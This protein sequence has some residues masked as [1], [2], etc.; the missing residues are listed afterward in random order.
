MSRFSKSSIWFVHLSPLIWFFRLHGYH[1]R[2]RFW[3]PVIRIE[4]SCPSAFDSE[5]RSCAA[6]WKRGA[7]TQTPDIIKIDFILDLEIWVILQQ[8]DQEAAD[9]NHVSEREREYNVGEGKDNTT[10]QNKNKKSENRYLH[11]LCYNTSTI[12][13]RFYVVFF[14]HFVYVTTN[15]SGLQKFWEVQNLQ[16][17]SDIAKIELTLVLSVGTKNSKHTWMQCKKLIV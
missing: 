6:V 13:P 8:S 4:S 10:K 2:S 15:K 17:L 3:F 1:L 12:K 7:S 11:V 9:C 5:R 16:G 14:V